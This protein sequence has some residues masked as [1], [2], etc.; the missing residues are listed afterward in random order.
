M[1]TNVFHI[2][3]VPIEYLHLCYSPFKLPAGTFLY[4]HHNLTNFKKTFDVLSFLLCTSDAPFGPEYKL[5]PKHHTQ[6]LPWLLY[7]I[8]LSLPNPEKF[9]HPP[10]FRFSFLLN[11]VAAFSTPNQHWSAGSFFFLF[12][13]DG[14]GAK[15]HALVYD[16]HILYYWATSRVQLSRSCCMGIMMSCVLLSKLLTPHA[17]WCLLRTTQSKQNTERLCYYSTHLS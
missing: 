10:C 11:P 12:S 4:R 1:A 14:S 5:L 13:F 16:K 17:A 15:I 6:H 9:L 7:K 8:L 2:S 3:T